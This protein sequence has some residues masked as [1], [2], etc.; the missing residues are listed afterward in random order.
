MIIFI[1]R[2]HDL[3]VVPVTLNLIGLLDV[4]NRPVGEQSKATNPSRSE[5]LVPVFLKG[6]TERVNKRFCFVA[7]VVPRQ[8]ITNSGC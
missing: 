4:S 5:W 8:L 7:L 6:I 3:V 1:V 2:S